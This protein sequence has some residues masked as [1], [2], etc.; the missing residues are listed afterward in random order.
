M[1]AGMHACMCS[2][3][4]PVFPT[5]AHLEARMSDGGSAIAAGMHADLHAADAAHARHGSKAGAQVRVPARLSPHQQTLS[6]HVLITAHGVPH[7]C[8]CRCFRRRRAAAA[9]ASRCSRWASFTRSRARCVWRFGRGR[10]P[11]RAP[12]PRISRSASRCLTKL[13]NSAGSGAPRRRLWAARGRS[14]VWKWTWPNRSMDTCL[15]CP[16]RSGAEAITISMTSRSRARS[17]RCPQSST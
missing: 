10:A 16:S 13:T 15:T 14:S 6:M 12:P 5:G 7:R 11:S 8:A 2:P 3:R 1:H 17:A 4:R 9:H